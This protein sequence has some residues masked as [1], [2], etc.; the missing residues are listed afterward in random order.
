MNNIC[1]EGRAT[2]EQEQFTRGFATKAAIVKSLILMFWGN[3][4]LSWSVEVV[5]KG[6]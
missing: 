3:M 4:R 5:S 6:S 2:V 1:R